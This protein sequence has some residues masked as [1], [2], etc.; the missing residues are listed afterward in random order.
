MSEVIDALER[1]GLIKRDPHP[2]HRRL[3]PAR[4]TAKGRRVLAACEREVDAMEAAM[5]LDLSSRERTALEESL[6]S[7]VR[8]LGAG[9]PRV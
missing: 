7:V 2:N 1:K 3:L 8:A 4:L 6:K 5:L 9:F